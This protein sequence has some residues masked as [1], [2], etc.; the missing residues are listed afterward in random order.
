MML[1]HPGLTSILSERLSEE[2]RRPASLTDPQQERTRENNCHELKVLPLY[3]WA[4]IGL[5]S[6]LNQWQFL[7]N[8]LNLKVIRKNS[9]QVIGL[10]WIFR[11]RRSEPDERVTDE[12]NGIQAEGTAWAEAQ[13]R[14]TAASSL[15]LVEF[16]VMQ[17]VV[18]RHLILT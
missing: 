3:D 13:K 6:I 10:G 5:M 15:A 17:T 12:E 7:G 8:W 4:N 9:L 14:E 18:N 1:F 2:I 11:I 16:K